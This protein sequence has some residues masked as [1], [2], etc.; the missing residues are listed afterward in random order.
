M[1]FKRIERPCA[2]IYQNFT[3][4]ARRERIALRFSTVTRGSD[5]IR[6]VRRAY[7]AVKMNGSKFP[8]PEGRYSRND[9]V[10]SVQRGKHESNRFINERPGRKP[11]PTACI[12]T[13]NARV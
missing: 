2:A 5:I 12:Y 1:Y 4:A 8:D 7:G 9:E 13:F 10:R 6:A 3:R 11:G